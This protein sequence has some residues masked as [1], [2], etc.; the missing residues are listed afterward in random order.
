M[1]MRIAP[2]AQSFLGVFVGI[3]GAGLI[4]DANATW[5]GGLLML[6]GVVSVALA[7]RRSTG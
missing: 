1:S 2:T 6:L 7:S 3:L 4:P 5:T